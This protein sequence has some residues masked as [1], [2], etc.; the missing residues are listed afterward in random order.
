MNKFSKELIESLTEACEHAE[1]KRV[2]SAFMWSKC[3]MCAPS[4]GSCECPNRNSPAST[5]SR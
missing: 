2:M 3:P 1:G 4:A 5:A